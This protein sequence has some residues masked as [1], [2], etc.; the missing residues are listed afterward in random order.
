MP[1]WATLGWDSFSDFPCLWESWWFGE[2]W[3]SVDCPSFGVRVVVCLFFSWLDWCL[4]ALGRK[5]T[6]TKCHPHHNVS[7][8]PDVNMLTAVGVDF[9]HLAEVVSVKVFF[10][11]HSILRSLEE[12]SRCSPCLVS[13][14]S[15]FISLRGQYLHQLLII[16]PYRDL[17]PSFI[18]LFNHLFASIQT[19]RYLFYPLSCYQICYFFFVHIVPTFDS[20]LS[21]F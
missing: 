16:F 2:V 10:V 17:S 18:C 15:S 5:T 11:S 1:P 6:E 3:L 9:D 13:G 20:G 14:E 12:V 19:H 21:Q 8:L 7:R 4:R